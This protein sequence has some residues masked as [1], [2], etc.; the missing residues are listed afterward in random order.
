MSP[1][2]TSNMDYSLQW[3]KILCD[4]A[5]PDGILRKPQARLP[6]PATS[7]VTSAAATTPQSGREVTHVHL[8]LRRTLCFRVWPI[9]NGCVD[10]VCAA[11]AGVWQSLCAA[12]SESF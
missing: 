10:S 12:E 4:L 8:V 1:G 2:N 9:E 6:T 11:V 5:R 3:T 7:A